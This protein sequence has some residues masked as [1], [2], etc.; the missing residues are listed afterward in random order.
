MMTDCWTER[1]MK[2]QKVTMTQKERQLGN[3]MMIL[4]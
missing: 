2:T 3:V 1:E 4:N